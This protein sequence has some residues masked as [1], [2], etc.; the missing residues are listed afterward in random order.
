M[1][2]FMY[3]ILRRKNRSQIFQKVRS[4]KDT[5]GYRYFRFSPDIDLLEVRPNGKVVGYE[6][7]GYTKSGRDP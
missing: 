1:F 3:R 7:K 6:L 5:G 2:L 4:S